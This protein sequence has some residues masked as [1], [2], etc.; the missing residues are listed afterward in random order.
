MFQNDLILVCSTSKSRCHG[1][2]EWSHG[3]RDKSSKCLHYSSLLVGIGLIC[4][5]MIRRIFW[6]SCCCLLLRDFGS[7]GTKTPTLLWLKP[8]ELRPHAVAVTEASQPYMCVHNKFCPQLQSLFH[9]ADVTPPPLLPPPPPLP[10]LLLS[11]YHLLH[12][13]LLSFT[14]SSS[15]LPPLL[16]LLLHL[17]YS[18]FTPPPPLPPPLLLLHSSFPLPPHSLLLLLSSTS[19]SLWLC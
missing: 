15:P 16:H 1:P 10:Y 7:S 12:H 4:D 19:S 5:V 9:T 3:L 14:T 6:R 13:L 2:L 8:E 11:L 17:L 18:S